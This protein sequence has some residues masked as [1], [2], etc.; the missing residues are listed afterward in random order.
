MKQIILLTC[1]GWLSIFPVYAQ[2]TNLVPQD[3]IVPVPTIA[4]LWK[5]PTIEVGLQKQLFVDDYLISHKQNIERDLNQATK[6]NNGEPLL[7]RDQPWEQANLFQ[8]N[9]VHFLD[10]KFVMHYGY[11]GPVDY[12]C[13][14]ESTDGLHWTKIRLGLKKFEGSTE[15]NLLDY[16]G[17]GFF[18]DPHET[19][20][21]HRFKSTFRPLESSGLPHAICLG[22]SEDGLHWHDYN[23]GQPVTGRASD[24][25]NQVAW[26]ERA[27]LY[28]L[29]TRTDFGSGGGPTELRGA[30][31][32]INP[33]I[34]ADPTNWT[35]VNEWIFDREGL[36]EGKRR[37]IHT[38][39]FWQHA[40]IDFGLFV[41]MEWP[42]FNI[43]QAPVG[44][45]IR[46]HERD[47]WNLYLATRRGGHESPWDLSW[48]YAAK[49][50]IPRGEDGTFDKDLIHPA[51]T[52]VTK[53]DK[54][55]LYYTGWPNGHMRHPYKPAIGLATFPLDRFVYL[56]SWKRHAPG[57]IITKPFE[58]TGNQLELNANASHGSLSVELLDAEG[59]PIPGFTATEV[60]PLKSQDGFRLRPRWKNIRDLS[61]LKGQ[62]IRL[63]ITLDQAELYALQVVAQ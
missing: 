60:I 22:Y 2:G 29:F 33:D 49:P 36:E 11:T 24:T 9:S 45:D 38:V 50:L 30:R 59:K 42:A 25:L 53:D 32:M 44:N 28:R 4:D 58:L 62:T 17:C 61:E 47:V 56:D 20:P 16:Q 31:E 39:N 63:K 14:A 37:Q 34:K 12:C 7:V 43:P 18:L 48:V 40:G 55:W 21:A 46:R 5:E 8:V 54:H 27:Q 26:D 19:D 3:E 35:T 1:V 51:C 13:R 41:V 15:N 10:G 57:W 52:V 23:D 6:E